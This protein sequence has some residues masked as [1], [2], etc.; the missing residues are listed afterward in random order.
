MKSPKIIDGT[1]VIFGPVRLSYTHVWE[2]RK[3]NDSDEGK[4]STAI[5]IPKD[6]KETLQALKQAIEAA[7]AKGLQKWGGKMPKTLALPLRDGDETE[8]PNYEG[9]VYL[10]A[11]AKTRPGIVNSKKEPITDEEE[12]YSGVWCYVSLNFFPYAASGNKGVAA[13][14]NNLMKFKDDDRFGGGASA[15]KD[16]DDFADEDAGDSD[17]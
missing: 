6:E 14:L 8:D 16:F 12:I 10:N 3:V 13:G 2:K 17:W 7:K 15:A 9:H 5:L 4:Y 1:R 11:S